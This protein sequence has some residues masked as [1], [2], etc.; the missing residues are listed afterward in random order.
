VND[1]AVH[2]VRRLGPIAWTVL[3]VLRERSVIGASGELVAEMSIRSLAADLGLAKNTVHRALR[4]LVR[5]GLI[6]A[7]QTRTIAGT[8]SRGHYVLTTEDRATG[9][10]PVD[11]HTAADHCPVQP[12]SPASSSQLTRGI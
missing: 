12:T 9:V 8:F 4:R 5:V 2:E 1:P 11:G 6:G 3:E 10:H 7:H